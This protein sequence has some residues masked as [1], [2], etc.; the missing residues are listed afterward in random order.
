[1]TRSPSPPPAPAPSPPR[2]TARAATITSPSTA[3]ARSSARRAPTR[4]I[5]TTSRAASTV[6]NSSTTADAAA[7]QRRTGAPHAVVEG[8]VGAAGPGE[9]RRLEAAPLGP[10]GHQPHV[11]PELSRQQPADRQ[12]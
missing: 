8:A 12:P 5:A 1:M 9:E 11:T 2:S 7:R 4:F 10:G 3:T 6:G